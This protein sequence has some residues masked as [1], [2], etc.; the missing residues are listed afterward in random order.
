MNDHG[1]AFDVRLKL[2]FAL[3]FFALATPAAHAAPVCHT[4]AGEAAKC[5]TADAMPLGWRRTE[6]APLSESQKQDSLRQLTIVV[7]GMIL[8]SSLIAL[9]P[10]FDGAR[11][12]D[13]DRQ[14]GE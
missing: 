8:F 2:I 11:G 4:R 12:A 6:N 10:D 1:D 5:G 7:C 13:W 9:L 3:A 14:E